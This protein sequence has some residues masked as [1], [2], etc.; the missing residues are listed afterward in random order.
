MPL[1]R[2]RRGRLRVCARWKGAIAGFVIDHIDEQLLR[3]DAHFLVDTVGMRLRRRRADAE[4]LLDIECVFAFRQQKEYLA[5][6]GG[7]RIL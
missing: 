6:S 4:L 1:R 2:L 7:T 3:A 5:F